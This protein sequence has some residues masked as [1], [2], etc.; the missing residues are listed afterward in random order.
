MN[1]KISCLWSD[2][3]GMKFIIIFCLVWVSSARAD[4]PIIEIKP[5]T[6]TDTKES[7]PIAEHR[8][9]KRPRLG[10]ATYYNFAD[11]VEEKGTLAY[12]GKDY[13]FSETDKGSGAPGIKVS[14]QHRFNEMWG[15]DYGLGYEFSRSLGSYSL[16]L[17]DT[18]TSGSNDPAPGFS[19]L[20]LEANGRFYPNE[21][22]YLLFGL[23]I[24]KINLTGTSTS[25]NTGAGGQF[26]VGYEITQNL[27]MEAQYRTVRA[28]GSKAGTIAGNPAKINFD[29]FDLSGLLLLFRY[30]P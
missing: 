23:S 12:L 18:T 13:S 4:E 5:P 16:N 6:A 2:M 21:N 17:N 1:L 8:P 10:I 19:L 26:G 22:L 28:S 29:S 27:S 11:R 3:D 7:A 9:S 14:L 24:N 20:F 15:L 30:T 25:L